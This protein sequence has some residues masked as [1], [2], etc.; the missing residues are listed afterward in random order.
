MTSSPVNGGDE[1]RFG[2]ELV[3]TV[4]A[5]EFLQDGRRATSSITNFGNWQ[6]PPEAAAAMNSAVVHLEWFHHTGELVAFSQIPYRGTGSIEVSAS[7]GAIDGLAGP[8][9]GA[10]G[11]MQRAD[12]GTLH[13]AFPAMNVDASTVVA[14]LAVVQHGP[15]VHERLL[16]WQREHR[17]DDGWDWLAARLDK[18]HTDTDTDTEGTDF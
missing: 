7:K 14:V 16:G 9:G 12:D 17:R 15:R 1:F 2:N 8:L 11:R 4:L 5:A 18:L 13:E 3:R 10:G 6:L